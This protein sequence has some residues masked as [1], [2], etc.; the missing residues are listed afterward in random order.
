[1]HKQIIKDLQKGSHAIEL[2]KISRSICISALKSAYWA[3]PIR[4][5]KIFTNFCPAFLKILVGW[6]G[7]LGTKMCSF[8]RARRDV[9]GEN[10]I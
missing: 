6:K 1:M 10:L 2:I 9:L 4:F 5:Y 3:N 8:D 7:S